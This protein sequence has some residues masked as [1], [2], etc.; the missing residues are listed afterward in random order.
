MRQTAL[1][2]AD[3]AE[4]GAATGPRGCWGLLT[5]GGSGVPEVAE[6]CT[7]PYRRAVSD[8]HLSSHSLP[9]FI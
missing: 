1:S 7:G 8:W 6:G 4:Y 9:E 5:Q 3:P 2:C